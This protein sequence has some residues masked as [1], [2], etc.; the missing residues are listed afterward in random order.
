LKYILL[1]FFD[2]TGTK[3]GVLEEYEQAKFSEK[4]FG[5]I[6]DKK[7][8]DQE[9]TRLK[10]MLS[11]PDAVG[12]TEGS[13]ISR[14]Y[15]RVSKP[16]R[17][18]YIKTLIGR[19]G[20]YRTAKENGVEIYVAAPESEEAFSKL[21][22]MGNEVIFHLINALNEI[23]VCGAEFQEQNLKDLK[24]SFKFYDTKMDAEGIIEKKQQNI[25]S[26]V[27][28]SYMIIMLLGCFEREAKL[29][30]PAI[31]D[32][33]EFVNQDAVKKIFY[34][35]EEDAVPYLINYAANS[36]KKK[37]K[38]AKN[39]LADIIVRFED[40][41]VR[42][43]NS[44]VKSS[45]LKA[46]K[47]GS[48]A[49]RA[50]VFEVFIKIMSRTKDFLE[51]IDKIIVGSANEE[52][53]MI[54]QDFLVELEEL[55][56][57]E[58]TPSAVNMLRHQNVNLRLNA[59]KFLVKAVPL[60]KK[61]IPDL[62]RSANDASWQIRQKAVYLLGTIYSRGSGKI[63][64]LIKRM[65][66][67]P[68]EEVAVSA[69]DAL[70]KHGFFSDKEVAMILQ[71]LGRRGSK[72]RSAV[73]E[74]VENLPPEQIQL[75]TA[76]LARMLKHSPAY[77]STNVEYCK[78]RG[79]KYVYVGRVP[80]CSARIKVSTP[81]KKIMVYS[82]EDGNRAADLLSVI[83]PK[84]VPH[85]LNQIADKDPMTRFRIAYVLGNMENLADNGIDALIKLSLDPESSVREA[86]V[87]AMGR[88]GFCNDKIAYAVADRL[89]DE[90]SYVRKKAYHALVG[91]SAK[92]V[93][94]LVAFI[95]NPSKSKDAKKAASEILVKIGSPSYG[96][97][98]KLLTHSNPQV[99]EIAAQA[100]KKSGYYHTSG[101]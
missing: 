52:N 20:T 21:F 2:S 7:I 32:K 92:A 10:S 36:D 44:H 24:R 64:T 55:I 51:R 30:I 90:S 81:V 72:V 26:N 6:A 1:K 23:D 28:K 63:F 5:L 45:M 31:M 83:G 76:V 93:K 40:E 66:N 98:D 74:I 95:K 8:T 101:K 17:T 91:F 46:V 12:K 88:L 29:A 68:K 86:S 62:I 16:D 15:G 77:I 78:N 94:P 35:M 37:T 59:I 41:L 42:G 70:K 34:S 89:E 56:R 79:K 57:K 13:L 43:N 61:Y 27:W 49:T 73:L 97:L 38:F 14:T 53:L 65:L 80:G 71:S 96:Y 47:N 9:V 11:I 67:D 39:V 58:I 54:T 100:L 3:R 22:N 75:A 85:I 69:A 99:R 4:L 48:P 50:A 82:Q 60:D 33:L 87:E 84:A 19:L 18:V 25:N